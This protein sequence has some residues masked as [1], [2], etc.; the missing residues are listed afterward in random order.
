MPTLREVSMRLE[1]LLGAHGLSRRGLARALGLAP[2]TVTHW[3]RFGEI[4]RPAAATREAVAAWLEVQGVPKEVAER[5][6]D[7][8]GPGVGESTEK[9]PTGAATPGGGSTDD[10]HLSEDT[11][12][13]LRR[14]PIH[15]ATR[16]HFRLLCDPFGRDLVSHEDVF[17]S[18]DVR[19]VRESMWSTALH[20]GLLAV[21]GESGSGKTT[22][23]DDIEDRIAREGAP[24]VLVRP[25][26]TGMEASDTKGRVLRVGH[27]QEAVVRS[28]APE[29]SLKSSPEARA[30]QMRTL[31]G[32]AR[33]SGKR[34]CVAF[35]EA[36]AMPVPTLKHLKRLLE[37]K[38]G[39]TRLLSIILLGQ[40]ELGLRLSER[41]PEVREVVARCE[42][43]TLDP[44]D[45][46]LEGYLRHKLAA[47][48][49]T[50]DE[51]VEPAG[52]DAI[53]ARLGITERGG[54]ASRAYPLLAGNLV[55]AA[56]NLAAEVGQPRV[57]AAT[58][59]RI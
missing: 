45:D 57:T 52:L 48:G 28:L 6:E 31:L 7:P 14:Q 58:V 35:D 10:D 42:V 36:H 16:R 53:R 26:V 9:V 47:A 4:R 33:D 39:F 43:V 46:Q 44:L 5:W 19:Y 38:Q 2:S 55:A 13:L 54:S 51:L 40:P 50:L 49:R 30:H 25:D 20:G 41:N 27:I 3:L 56:L 15:Q 1:R 59:G 23:L 8:L 29:A 11:D 17:E 18:P 34:V 24:V 22:L 21:V 37:I 32:S 12:M